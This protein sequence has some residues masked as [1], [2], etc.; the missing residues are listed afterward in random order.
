[1]P[2]Q[3]PHNTV[4]VVSGRRRRVLERVFR[5]LKH[6]GMASENGFFFRWG[7]PTASG[8][9]SA[10]SDSGTDMDMTTEGEGEGDDEE[11]TTADDPRGLALRGWNLLHEHLDVS[12][13]DMAHHVMDV[14]TKVRACL[15][16]AS[17]LL[18]VA[19]LGWPRLMNRLCVWRV[20]CG[21]WRVF[22]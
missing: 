2:E 9:G 4:F 10:A 21:V 3:D 12:W 15:G 11:E 16:V 20:A 6:V 18:L 17:W 5:G 19:V 7:R 14:Y 8:T 13:I 22:V 1:M